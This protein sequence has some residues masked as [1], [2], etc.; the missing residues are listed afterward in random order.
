MAPV[1]VLRSGALQ[2]AV[3]LELENSIRGNLREECLSK[4][5]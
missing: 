4:L 5:A 1:F 3:D 2:A